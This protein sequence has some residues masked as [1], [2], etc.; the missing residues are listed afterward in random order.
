MILLV[1]CVE[2][3]DLAYQVGIL[4]EELFKFFV[5]GAQ[6]QLVCSHDFFCFLSFCLELVA[7]PRV[8]RTVLQV[9][10]GIIA[11]FIFL[12]GQTSI[13]SLLHQYY[14]FV[15]TI[16]GFFTVSR[17]IFLGRVPNIKQ[18]VI[19]LAIFLGCRPKPVLQSHPLTL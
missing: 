15:Y 2:L 18:K 17:L 9:G 5:F 10:K 12:F 16:Y 19:I 1:F 4:G 11:V 6:S 8:L 13:Y 3:L 14:G 7:D